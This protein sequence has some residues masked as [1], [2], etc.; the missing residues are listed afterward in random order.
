MI[1]IISFLYKFT[2]QLLYCSPSIWPNSA[3][4]IPYLV[5]RGF[6]P[7]PLL[8]GHIQLTNDQDPS[9][10]MNYVFNKFRD[11]ISHSLLR[12]QVI[13]EVTLFLYE[14]WIHQQQYIYFALIIQFITYYFNS[15][16]LKL[17]NYACCGIVV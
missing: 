16:F 17:L 6:N 10:H 11:T 2:T 8:Y 9:D 13:I 5:R 14:I 12:W 3:V 15:F 1:R 7:S 4:P